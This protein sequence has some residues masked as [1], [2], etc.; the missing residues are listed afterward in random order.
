MGVETS[1]K[2]VTSVAREEDAPP[3]SKKSQ[4]QAD[5]GGGYA[6]EIDLLESIGDLRPDFVFFQESPDGA[7]SFGDETRGDA[8]AGHHYYDSGDCATLSR[9]PCEVLASKSAGPWDEPQML[10][11]EI[12]GRR[13]LLVNVRLMAPA[14]ILNP[15]DARSREKLSQDNRSRRDHY[16]HLVELIAATQ[17]EHPIDHVIHAGDFNTDASAKSLNVIRKN[18]TDIWHARGTGWGGTATNEF[19]VARIDHIYVK[20]LKP[21]SVRVIQSP[22]SDHLPVVATLSLEFSTSE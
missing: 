6:S 1:E 2:N 18:L 19:P 21:N 20:H 15:F 12:E 8:F 4:K 5:I 14:P 3:P 16:P 9:W 7:D 10:P 17:S 11:A 13:G 22:L